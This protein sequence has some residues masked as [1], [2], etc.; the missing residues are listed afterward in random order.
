MGV[1]PMLNLEQLFAKQIEAETIIGSVTFDQAIAWYFTT[2]K[3]TFC[4]DLLH[5]AADIDGD[6]FC[7]SMVGDLEKRFD[8]ILTAYLEVLYEIRIVQPLPRLEGS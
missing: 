2:E 4:L 1:E 5:L 3:F 7:T 8:Q 6:S